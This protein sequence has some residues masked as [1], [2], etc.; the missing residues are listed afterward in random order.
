MKD[1]GCKRWNSSMR[2][3]IRCR[4]LVLR[5]KVRSMKCEM[6]EIHAYVCTNIV[7]EAN[8]IS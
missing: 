1:A 2:G 7:R 6:W 8:S 3:N 5:N 4:M